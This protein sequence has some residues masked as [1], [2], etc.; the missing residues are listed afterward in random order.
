MSQLAAVSTAPSTDVLSPA[1]APAPADA[2]QAALRSIRP[3]TRPDGAPVRVVDLFAGIG[4]LSLG[5][6]QAAAA[7][8]RPVDVALAVDR[9][10]AAL[11]VFSSVFPSADVTTEDVTSLVDGA[12]GARATAAERALR[13]R[14]G[15]VD[16]LVG[17]PPCQGHSAL[18]NATRH[19]D[20]RN[21]LYLRMARAAEVLAPDT[22]VVENVPGARADR[23]GVVDRTVEHLRGL[24]YG[25][26]VEVVDLSDLGVAQR[27]RRLVL[28]ATRR[29]SV[30]L[31]EVVQR[32]RRPSRGVAWAIDD[33]ADVET[34]RLVDQRA[35]SAA[36]TRERIAYLFDHDVY[37][38]PNELRP[39][40]HRGD[41]SYV[42]IYGRMRP[43]QPAQTITRGF[44]SM[45]MGRYVHPT[46]PRTITAHEA[47]RLQ[48]IPD[49]VDFSSIR[50]RGQLALAIGNA[51]PPRLTE[52][53][54]AEVLS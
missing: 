13:R 40:C 24:G 38:L 17:G 51:V 21:E 47:A 23:S 39:A 11:G 8:G 9:D 41:H 54:G 6:S 44:Y 1:D 35:R 25:V 42:S 18:N 33:L 20:D 4:G 15:D 32:H 45:C 19:R 7:V 34:D 2:D 30:S 10:P 14:V 26:S 28:L 5:V 46:R 3:P 29:A 22:V 36:T 50:K 43:D 48:H 27:R 49:H 12:L 53:I 52:A 16:V 31:A 37:D